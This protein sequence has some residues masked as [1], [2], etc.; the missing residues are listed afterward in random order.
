MTS[1]SQRGE[2]RAA[3]AA[4]LALLMLTSS[5]PGKELDVWIGTA[6]QPVGRSRGIYHLVFNDQSGDL[7][8][9]RLV[10]EV[11][12]PGFLA[13]H[14]SLPVLYATAT[15]DDEASVVA[16]RIG[17]DGGTAALE[18]ISAQPIG[19]DGAAHLSVD[20]TGSVL[21]TAQYGGG[22]VASYRLREDGSIAERVS[23]IE[24]DE[25]SGVVPD[26]QKECHP[27]SAM[28]SPDGR[29]VLVP[30]LGA[31][32]VYVY[33]LDVEAGELNPHNSVKCEPGGGPRHF[34][35]HPNG[36]YGY[37]VNELSMAVSSFG[38]DTEKGELTLLHSFPTLTDE[39]RAGEVSNSASE[40]RVHP[41]GK[42]VYVGNRGH[43]SVT[44]FRIEE[45]P[46]RL[47]PI[48]LEPIRGSHP[49]HFA[50]SPSGKWLLAAGRDSNTVA[51][52]SIDGETGALQWTLE[53]DYVPAP[54]CVLIV[55]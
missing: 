14:P 30:D 11:E 39:Q 46:S 36:K 12:E 53:S 41:S 34:A 15:L 25:P 2:A 21:L 40:V 26:R 45:D 4:T 28:P 42:V 1:L 31:D 16:Y 17:R 55:P 5:A 18:K 32:R 38:W 24:H 3:L 20:H 52:F 13:L 47:T 29:W 19:D 48:D 50:V 43:D 27:H 35:F 8:K 49:R 22:S 54:T 10:A 7:S 9:A 51:V 37:V 23:L 6:T 44:A 33:A